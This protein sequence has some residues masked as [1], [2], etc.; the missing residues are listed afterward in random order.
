MFMTAPLGVHSGYL[1]SFYRLKQDFWWQGMKFDFKNYIK[2]CVVYQQMKHETCKT[3]W[4]V[5]ATP[6]SL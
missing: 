3:S 5:K 6:H 1:K 4:I 2:E